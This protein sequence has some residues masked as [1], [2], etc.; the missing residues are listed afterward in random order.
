MAN[1]TLNVTV[2]NRNKEYTFNGSVQVAA[3]EDAPR[4]LTLYEEKRDRINTYTLNPGN[5]PWKK[6]MERVR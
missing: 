4:L 2:W 1:F 6:L 3:P 5:L